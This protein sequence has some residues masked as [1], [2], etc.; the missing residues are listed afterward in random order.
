[1]AEGDRPAYCG[2]CGNLVQEGDRFCGTCGATILAPA[3]QAERVTPPQVA[4]AQG[5]AA[6]SRS[7]PLL[8]VGVLGALAVLLVGGGALAFVGLGVGSNL[9]GGSEQDPLGDSRGAAPSQPEVTQGADPPREPTDQTRGYGATE[10][11][12]PSSSGQPSYEEQEDALLEGFAREYDEA[13]RREDWEETYSMLDAS[14]QQEFTE[15]EWAEKQR[16][17]LD[18]GGVQA[19]LESVTVDQNEEV[20]DTP[21]RV[22]LY[23]EDGSEETIV[24]GVPMVVEDESD[25]GVPKRFLIEEEI[26]ELEQIPS[27]TTEPTTLSP[28]PTT[29][30]TSGPDSEEA[31]A[32]V[33][34][35]AG[36]YYR[37]AGVEDWA[38]TYENLD[39][40]TRSGFTEEEWFEKNQWLADNGEVIYHVD[41]VEQV[42]TSDEYFGVALTL[43]YEDGSS[44]TRVTY[45]VYEDGGWKHRFGGEE[46][47]LLMPGVPFEEFVEAQGGGSSASPESQQ[48]APPFPEDTNGGAGEEI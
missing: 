10:A 37:A 29:P 36:D 41:S 23:Y 26:A 25:S 19:P 3:P 32:Q 11:T 17:L 31:V 27:A 18:N 45:F 30:G 8:L 7:R 33:E 13:S 20:T 5:S 21:A 47:D 35:A 24:A 48:T 4:A 39:D 22:T 14:S 2:Q 9:L 6:R 1:M 38:Y 46:N 16:A 15:D 43:T 42:G 44:S 40:E 34:E 28:E 12:T